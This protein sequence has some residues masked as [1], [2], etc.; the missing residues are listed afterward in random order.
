MFKILE[1]GEWNMVASSTVYVDTFDIDVEQIVGCTV[2]ILGDSGDRYSL[3]GAQ[4][5]GSLHGSW[6]IDDTYNRIT[7][8][9]AGSGFFDNSNFD[10]TAGTVANRGW[11]VISYI[12]EPLSV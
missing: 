8:K 9:R 11:C 4:L 1:I 6:Q 10:G 3:S 5:T 12:A 2:T 7:L